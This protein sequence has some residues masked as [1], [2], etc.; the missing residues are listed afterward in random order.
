MNVGLGLF[1]LAILGLIFLKLNATDSSPIR[2]AIPFGESGSQALPFIISLIILLP[3]VYI[4]ISGN[5]TDEVQKWAF[6]ASGTILGYWFGR[7]A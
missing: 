4:I 2:K 3:A 1:V 6:G 5:Y 7:P